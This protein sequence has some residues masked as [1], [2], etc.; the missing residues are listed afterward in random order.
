M[1]EELL[2]QLFEEYQEEDNSE[3]LHVVYLNTPIDDYSENW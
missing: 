2:A 1:E 3:G